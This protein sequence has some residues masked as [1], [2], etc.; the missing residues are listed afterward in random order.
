MWSL[1]SKRVPRRI[2]RVLSEPHHKDWLVTMT[3]LRE[4]QWADACGH[5][6]AWHQCDHVYT[7]LGVPVDSIEVVE[8]GTAYI[9]FCKQCGLE[10]ERHEKE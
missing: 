8:T 1:C 5:P 2:P 6:Q 3:I 9:R 7:F 4:V 10:V